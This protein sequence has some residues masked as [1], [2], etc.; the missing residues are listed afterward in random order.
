MLPPIEEQPYHEVVQRMLQV[1]YDYT[2]NRPSVYD[3][4]TPEQIAAKAVAYD[5]LRDLQFRAR[6]KAF[7]DGYHDVA[8]IVPPYVPATPTHYREERPLWYSAATSWA[9][10]R[11]NGQY[12]KVDYWLGN[13]RSNKWRLNGPSKVPHEIP[14]W[15]RRAHCLGSHERLQQEVTVL[16]PTGDVYEYRHRP[17]LLEEMTKPVRKYNLKLMSDYWTMWEGEPTRAR[18]IASTMT[19]QLEWKNK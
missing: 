5:K 15:F 8:V 18:F 11:L 16:D 19:V 6:L 9:I 3:R 14:R 4:P 13:E 1:A 7:E 2:N 12:R 10:V 17:V